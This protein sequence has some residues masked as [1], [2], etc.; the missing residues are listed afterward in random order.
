MEREQGRQM[1]RYSPGYGD[2]DISEQ[3]KLFRLVPG[4]AIGVH[5]SETHQMTP[6]KSV[7]AMIG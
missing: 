2:W 7:S 4:D 1:S 3:A 5:L 6:E